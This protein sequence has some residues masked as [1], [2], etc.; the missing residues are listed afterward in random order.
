MKKIKK[1]ILTAGLAG[2]LAV[3]SVGCGE[4]LSAYDIAVK[5]GFT[6]TEA[7]W[8]LSLSGKKGADGQ[9]LDARDLYEAAKAEGYEGSFLDFCKTLEISLPTDNDTAQIS[10]NMLSVV[11]IYCGYSITTQSGDIIDNLLG[12]G[13]TT[14][15]RSQAGSGVIVDLN[16]EAGSAYIVTNYHVVYN[17][18][19]DQKGILKD[20]WVYPY[21]ATN[22]FDTK[23]GDEGGEGIKATYVGGAMDY[24]IAVLKIEGSEYLKKNEVR[25]AKLGDSNSLKAGAQTYVIGN[26]GGMG[27]S[28]T[29]GVIS[30][31]YEYINM[32]A[33][34]D[35][36]LDGDKRADSIAYR[37]I[38]TS[39]AINPGNSGGG[40]FNAKGEL[41]GIVNAKNANSTTDNM[42]YALPVTQMKAIYDNI[43]AN[44]DRVE[45]ATLGIIV[46]V[47]STD[48]RMD[49]EGN[50]S[51]VE[52][53]CVYT[54]AEEGSAA[55]QKLKAGDVFLS[56]KIEGGEETVFS[57][58]HQLTEFLLTVRKGQSAIFKVRNASGE[59]E[60]I[61]ITFG[62][63]NFT[64]FA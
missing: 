63:G 58:R 52:E 49:E 11:S 12:G 34:D 13:K 20:I 45:Q 48:V 42:G 43:F 60:E 3:G 46:T 30:V 33:I 41:I 2:L 32:S 24:D 50:A 18:D 10:E 57:H 4:A 40:M 39:A 8:L 7:E 55:Y 28:V 35:R 36:D 62:E 54:P 21:G 22:R 64:T 14:E 25:E 51:I 17:K 56:A 15:Y 16:K 6:G 53:F 31:P 26:P 37:V 23:E 38:R 44:G 29:N 1:A 59:V 9:D 19:S 27:I 47:K 61:T 5:N